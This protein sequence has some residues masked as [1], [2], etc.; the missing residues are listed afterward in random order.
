MSAIRGPAD[1]AA[2]AALCTLLVPGA[3][4]ARFEPS[5]TASLTGEGVWGGGFDPWTPVAVHV[6]AADG[7][8]TVFSTTDADGYF[9][10]D[11]GMQLVPGTQVVVE[12]GRWTRE[13]TLAQLTFDLLG[14]S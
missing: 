7:T 11:P 1:G 3:A 6:P 5:I 13:L 9:E 14:R 2:A 10:A 4:A 12:S 8:V